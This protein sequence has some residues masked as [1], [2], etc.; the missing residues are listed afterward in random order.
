MIKNFSKIAIANRG[1]MAVRIIR[2]AQELGISTLLLHSEADRDSIAYRISDEQICIGASFVDKSY[3]NLEAVLNGAVSGK[4]EALHPGVG[5]LSENPQLARACK[6]KEIE[7]IGPSEECLRLL[8]QKQSVCRLAQKLGVPTLSSFPVPVSP[9]WLKFKEEEKKEKLK[10]K[11]KKKLLKAWKDFL[12]KAETFPYPLMAKVSQGGGG[13]GLRQVNQFEELEEAL[14]SA[15]REGQSSFQSEDVFLESYL[16]KARHVEVQMFGGA[17]GYIY[18]LG[19]RDGSIQRRHQKVIEEA[20]SSHLSE[21]MRESIK[22]AS[23]I[24]MKNLDHPF[25][26]AATVEF[27]VKGKEF[28]FLEINPRLQVE[29]PLTEVL[30][31][32]DLV[33][34]QILTAQNKP[35]FWDKKPQACEL[36]GHAIECRIFAEDP[37]HLNVNKD[38]SPWPSTGVLGS[39]DWPHGPGRRFDIGFEKGDEITSFYDSLLAKVIVWDETRL[40]AIK[41][42]RQTLKECILFGLKTNIP[43]LLSLLEDEDFISWNTNTHFISKHFLN[44]S[45]EKE[46]NRFLK[47]DHLNEEEKKMAEEIH[48]KWLLSPPGE[49][50]VFPSQ[51]SFESNLESPWI[52]NWDMED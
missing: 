24:L 50:S 39:C 18:C 34:A 47:Q 43:Y 14:E 32:V 45:Q 37:F 22:E 21:E 48:E 15:M 20:P 35:V 27:L 10:P 26:S 41:K 30:T 2:G 11:H 16:N 52:Y 44:F 17:D 1:E 23:F 4:A 25:K 51:S 36:R 5:F 9:F 33:K 8:A 28:Y 38:I 40:R 12:K 6:E 3:L 31:G 29:H 42:M 46:R 49:S 7:F 13:R 19:D